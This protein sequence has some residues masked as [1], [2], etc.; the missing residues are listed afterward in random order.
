MWDSTKLSQ[1]YHPSVPRVVPGGVGGGSEEVD[2]PLAAVSGHDG[3]HAA[4]GAKTTRVHANAA[5][6][7]P[8]DGHHDLRRHRA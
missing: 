4:C 3:H 6:F 2:A 5:G 8:Q 1:T 7:V